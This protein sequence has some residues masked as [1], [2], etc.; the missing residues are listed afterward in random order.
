[1]SLTVPVAGDGVALLN[2]AIVLL[3][4]SWVIFAMRLGVRLWRK[5]FG[6]DDW[7]MLIG[8]VCE[9]SQHFEK[10]NELTLICRFFSQSQQRC[11]SSVVLMVL[12]NSLVIYLP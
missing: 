4:L 2:G 11:A 3:V 1:M 8:S 7:L 6:M 12:D 9:P 10:L 5:A